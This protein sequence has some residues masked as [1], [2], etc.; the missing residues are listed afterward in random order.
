VL[1]LLLA[2]VGIYSVLA[3]SV[4][5]RVREISIRL[6][7]GAQI[8][9][10]LRLVVIEGMKPT[11][12]GVAIGLAVSLAVGPLL[13]S[14]IYGVTPTDPLTFAAVSLILIAV[15]LLACVIPALRA[16][17]VAPLQAL[18]EE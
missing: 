16:T 18:R 13:A 4:R 1:A 11:L 15:A 6:A 8:S 5:K 12:F 17:R 2:A 10:V 9:D 14:L 3:Y 7:L